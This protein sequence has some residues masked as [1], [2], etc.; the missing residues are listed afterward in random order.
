MGD[1]VKLLVIVM[2]TVRE[3]PTSGSAVVEAG[4]ERRLGV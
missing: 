2:G 4:L 3:K 1:P